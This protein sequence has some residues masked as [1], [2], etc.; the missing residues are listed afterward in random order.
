MDRFECYDKE[1][2]VTFSNIGTIGKKVGFGILSSSSWH[3]S[4]SP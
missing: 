1:S 2:L 4:V 3:G